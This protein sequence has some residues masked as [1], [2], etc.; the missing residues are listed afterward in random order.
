[1]KILD[2]YPENEFFGKKDD[3]TV[4]DLFSEPLMQRGMVIKL[5]SNVKYVSAFPLYIRGSGN[6]SCTP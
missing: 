6:K 5:H 2:F 1:M 3:R 4:K